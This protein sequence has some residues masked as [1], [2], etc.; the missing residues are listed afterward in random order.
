M[1]KDKEKKQ[2]KKN[3]IDRLQK[4]YETAIEMLKAKHEKL[5]G[6]IREANIYIAELREMRDGLKAFLDED[7]VN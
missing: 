2:K 1:A 7:I 6:L 3:N 5:D 4:D